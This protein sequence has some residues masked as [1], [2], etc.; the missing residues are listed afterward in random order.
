MLVQRE[1]LESR[2]LKGMSDQKVTLVIQD[3]LELQVQQDPQ[4][5]KVLMDSQHI[6]LH[7]LKDLLEPKKSGL[8]V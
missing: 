6:R 4:A 5:L 2:D 1:I 3:Q 8:Q 7:R